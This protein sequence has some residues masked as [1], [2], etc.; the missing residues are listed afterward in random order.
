V[1]AQWQE[2]D[3][4][5]YAFTDL[6]VKVAIN[7]E[8]TGLV[9]G[10]EMYGDYHEGQKLKAYIKCVRDDGRIDVALQPKKSRHVFSATEKILAHLK[11]AGGKSG[12]GDASSAEDIKK[13]FQISKKMFKQAIG[14]LYKQHKIKITDTGIE[15]VK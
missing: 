3:A 4:E 6:G 5:I 14:R 9:Y 8:Y 12:F 10:N 7:D 13:E 2:V 15:L 1:F 11:A